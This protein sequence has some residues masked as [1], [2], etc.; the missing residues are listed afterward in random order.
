MDFNQLNNKTANLRTNSNEMKDLKITSFDARNLNST[1]NNRNSNNLNE[2]TRP[3]AL[4]RIFLE[5]F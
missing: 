2:T 1:I 4:L 5:L 3:I